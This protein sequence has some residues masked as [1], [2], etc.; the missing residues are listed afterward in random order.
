M[1]SFSTELE[2]EKLEYIEADP[3]NPFFAS[4]DG[5]LFSKDLKTLISYPIGNSRTSYAIPSGVTKIEDGTFY[6][7]YQIPSHPIR[8]IIIP[9]SVENIEQ[10]AISACAIS[11][12]RPFQ[13]FVF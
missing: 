7:I 11:G 9:D 5:V 13:N 4:V 10:D 12:T 6:D 2:I 8:D 3:D 1:E